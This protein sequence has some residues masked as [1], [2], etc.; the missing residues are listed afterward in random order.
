VV[1][2]VLELKLAVRHARSLKE[3]RQVINSLK[4]RLRNRYNVSIAEVDSHDVHQIAEIG[5]V[6]VGSDARYARGS[7]DSIVDVV[8][9]FRGAQLTD[10]SVE[11]FHH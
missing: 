2:A 9:R 3:K 11:I 6:Q 10:Y 1:I 8:R 7:L 5:V 4:D